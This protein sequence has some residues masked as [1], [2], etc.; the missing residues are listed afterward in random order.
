MPR[1]ERVVMKIMSGLRVLIGVVL[2]LSHRKRITNLYIEK[3]SY[4]YII[5]L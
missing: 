4:T 2:K 3:L 5:E 1:L